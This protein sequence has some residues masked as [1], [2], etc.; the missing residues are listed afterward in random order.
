MGSDSRTI[1]LRSR[2]DLC[3]LEAVADAAPR[4]VARDDV[5]D[6]LTDWWLKVIRGLIAVAKEHA[7]QAV[8]PT[9]GDPVVPNSPGSAS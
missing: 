6:A 7:E 1:D 9:D 5:P 4:L 2:D 3:Y 8:A